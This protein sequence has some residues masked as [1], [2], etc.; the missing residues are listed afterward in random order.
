MSLRWK[1]ALTLS[2]LAMT[3]TAAIG[4]ASY[5]LTSARLT[6]EIDGSLERVVER[7]PRGRFGDGDELA[8]RGPLDGFDA[9]VIARDGSVRSTFEPPVAPSEAASALVGRP[10][11][12]M[13]E[14]ITV[15][16]TDYRVRTIGGANG[17]VQVARSLDETERVLSSLR[18]RTLMVSLLVAAA[19]TLIGL[20]IAGR[21]TASLRRLTVAAEHVGATGQLDASVGEQ[22]SDEV[23][24]LAAA[25]DAM[26]AAL[27]GSRRD[28]QRL[29]QDAG[30][31]LRT[32]LTSLRTN[33]DTLRRYPDLAAADRDAIVADLPHRPPDRG[34]RG[35]HAG[36]RRA[37]RGATCRVVPARQRQQVRH[38]AVA[39]RDHRRR[40]WRRRRRSRH[41][42]PAQRA[43][44]GVRAVPSRRGGAHVAGQRARAGDRARG[45]AP[46]R[47]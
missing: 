26:L 10:G 40:R 37:G 42:H 18:R 3:A 19:A 41:G 9:Q 1:I 47:R 32:P 35:L 5:R 23:G 33:L 8:G 16:G 17:A 24:R 29:V 43:A 34:D 2:V 45:G 11:A 6:D 7:L 36:R 22:G 25:F 27:A 12:E 31:E 20:W 4:V 44:I 38:V 14:T 30:H 13:F 21:V 15:D 39:D 28:Q 46:P